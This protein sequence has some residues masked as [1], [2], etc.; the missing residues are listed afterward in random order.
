MWGGGTSGEPSSNRPGYSSSRFLDNFY[1]NYDTRL[2]VKNNYQQK[3]K[4]TCNFRPSSSSIPNLSV[5]GKSYSSA[6]LNR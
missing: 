2:M 4:K 3:Q 1:K 6:D 5:I